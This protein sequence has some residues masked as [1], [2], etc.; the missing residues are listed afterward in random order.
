MAGR[1][2]D[3]SPRQ[4][5][6]DRETNPPNRL[7]A[8]PAGAL[9]AK[10]VI[11]ATGDGDIFARAG[12]EFENDIDEGDVHHSMN[13]GF[14]TAGVDMDRWIDF[15]TLQ[16]EQFSDF[17]QRGR[18]RLGFFQPPMS[19]GAKTLRSSWARQ[20]G[21]SGLDIDDMTEVE[22]HSHRF[23]ATHCNFF[24]QNAPGFENAY[25]LQSASQR[26]QLARLHAGDPA[27]L[28]DRSGRGRRSRHRSQLRHSTARRERQRRSNALRKQGVLI[29]DPD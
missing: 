3:G 5:L 13:T 20:S 27:V 21:L 8:R 14:L 4:P 12:P 1:S 18:D 7:K 9:R 15:R 6:G 17:M 11:D 24:R 16:R 10:V 22:I 25:M 29:R 19:H 23:M 26:R 2:A 28:A